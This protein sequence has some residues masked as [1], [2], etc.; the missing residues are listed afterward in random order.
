MNDLNKVKEINVVHDLAYANKHLANGWILIAVNSVPARDSSG[1]NAIATE[2]VLGWEHAL[3][4]K[5]VTQDKS[6]V[7]ASKYAPQYD[8]Y[9]AEKKPVRPATTSKTNQ[10]PTKI[11]IID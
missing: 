11:T 5:K 2:Y 1:K 7:A 6:D 3:P 4:A 8:D 10:K 9:A